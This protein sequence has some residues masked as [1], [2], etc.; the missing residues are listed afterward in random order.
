MRLTETKENGKTYHA[1]NQPMVKNGLQM[2]G[3]IFQKEPCR[4]R[5]TLRETDFSYVTRA[6]LKLLCPQTL[7]RYPEQ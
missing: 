2:R 6:I 5:Y 4:L 7:R 1:K 3:E